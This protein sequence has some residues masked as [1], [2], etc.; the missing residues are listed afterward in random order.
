MEGPTARACLLFSAIDDDEDIAAFFMLAPI[1]SIDGGGHTTGRLLGPC[2][3]DKDYGP[4]TAQSRQETVTS[5]IHGVSRHVA[6]ADWC[7][8]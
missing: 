7:A 6:I 1:L 4:W 5:L 3:P 8:R 2:R